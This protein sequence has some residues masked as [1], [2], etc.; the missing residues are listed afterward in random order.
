MG[1]SQSIRGVFTGY[2][3]VSVMCRL[4]IGYVSEHTRSFFLGGASTTWMKEIEAPARCAHEILINLITARPVAYCVLRNKLQPRQ[5]GLATRNSLP[6]SRVATKP[7]K[8]ENEKGEW[9]RQQKQPFR[10]TNIVP[11]QGRFII[12]KNHSKSDLN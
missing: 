11:R 1:Y 9:G 7:V 8:T 6:R 12:N 3:Y 5:N 2:S 10:D 4:C